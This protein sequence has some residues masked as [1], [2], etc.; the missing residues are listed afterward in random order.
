MA[1]EER[2]HQRE[3]HQATVPSTQP[4]SQP[5]RNLPRRKLLQWLG[6]AGLGGAATAVSSKLW[7]TVHRPTLPPQLGNLH[8]MAFDVITIDGTGQASCRRSHQAKVFREEL[9]R[10][11]T[12]ELVAIPGGRFLMGSPETE[13]ERVSNE[14]PQRQVKVAPFY[15]GKFAVTQAQWQVV[16]QLPRVQRDLNPDP[17]AFK[18]AKHPV[19]Q[20]SWYEAIEFCARLS[21]LT[22]R[23]YRLPSE[24]EWEYACRAETHTPFS[25]GET[26]T[27]DLVNF[28]GTGWN[29]PEQATSGQYH[30][31]PKGRDRHQTTEVGSFPPNWFG[32]Y[33]MHGNVWEWCAD[34]YYPDYSDLPKNGRPRT[35]K[36]PEF[37]MLRGG[38]WL[39]YP[40]NCRSAYRHRNGA[41]AT[42]DVI[43]FRVVCSGV[44]T[45]QG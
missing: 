31:D 37:R 41:D 21:R 2:S 35:G 34:S 29:E 1:P 23:L 7:R 43:G 28:R 30:P 24:A 6:L 25:F 8:A 26:I 20:V 13:A 9:G 18:G 40:W 5:G 39:S 3:L 44:K 15:M 22:G 10:G 11:V 32:L 17:A 36:N 27:T 14:G 4:A 33:E 12:L 45:S 38:S 19:E 16:A 42:G